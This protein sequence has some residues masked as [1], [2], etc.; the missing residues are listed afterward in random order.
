MA[1]PNPSDTAAAAARA[2]RVFITHGKNKGFIEPAKK[3]LSFGELEAVVAAEKQTVAQ[4]VPEKVMED[5][6]SCGAAIIHVD[7]ERRLL[8]K[9]AKEK[10]RRITAETCELEA[11]AG[12][13]PLGCRP[14]EM[15]RGNH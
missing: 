14:A 1:G 2:R 13:K 7:D 10:H 5:M 3:L 9:E 6:R 11:R 4:P 8:D 15:T 12:P